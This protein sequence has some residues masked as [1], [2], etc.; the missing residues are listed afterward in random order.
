VVLILAGYLS[1]HII[2]P[3]YIY[4]NN[5]PTKDQNIVGGENNTS[6]IISMKSQDSVVRSNFQSVEQIDCKLAIDGKVMAL[7]VPKTGSTSFEL[8][9][10][11]AKGIHPKKCAN[12]TSILDHTANN[13]GKLHWNVMTLRDPVARFK[14]AYSYSNKENRYK[15]QEEAPKYRTPFDE[16]FLGA[17]N[18]LEWAD[19]LLRDSQLCAAWMAA[20]WWSPKWRPN[21]HSRLRVH[22]NWSTFRDRQ[23]VYTTPNNTLIDTPAVCNISRGRRCGFVP[24]ADYASVCTRFVCVPFI[25]D[26]SK[27]Q[28]LEHQINDGLQFALND[29]VP[30]CAI[31]TESERIENVRSSI[32]IG[33]PSLEETLLEQE[34]RDAVQQLYPGDIELWNRHCGEEKFH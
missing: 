10:Q 25:S 29:L 27:T 33:S 17:D 13:G 15:W 31:G 34:L 26:W 32:N 16:A 30:G 20:P 3:G 21:Q 2:Y 24:Q 5:A 7:H 18:A 11:A 12:L 8:T 23:G 1:M 4:R 9:I 22:G 28:G 14:S 6:A 19:I